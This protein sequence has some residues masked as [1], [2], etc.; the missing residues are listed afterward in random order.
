[1][2]LPAPRSLITSLISSLASIPVVDN[3]GVP[4]NNPA[5]SH[6]PSNQPS[7]PLRLIPPAY[8]SLLTTLHVL[9]PTTLL[10]A[11]DL[12]D[13]RLVTRIFL[14]DDLAR[15]QNDIRTDPNLTVPVNEDP[16]CINQEDYE[17][18]CDDLPRYHLVRS[19]QPQSHR[20]QHQH[21]QQ[22]QS[23]SSDQVYIV[24]LQSWNCT[25][26]AFAFSAFPPLS[27]PSF[28]AGSEQQ[29]QLAAGSAY[30]IFPA[31]SNAQEEEVGRS[32]DIDV[33]VNVDDK[34]DNND[35][36]DAVDEPW[37]FGGLST[38]G[39]DG[40][41]GVPCCKHLLACV[42]AERWHQVLGGYIEERV[43]SKEEGAGLVGDL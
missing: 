25:C 2:T 8:R 38:D 22:Q 32:G 41:G 42:L 18:R 34:D 15:H 29:Q 21:Q 31:S 3:A 9:Y 36:D 5:S 13:R 17:S 14:K 4:N 7:N 40:T 11:L 23:S 1:M 27:A 33:D 24:C 43:V 37:E 20:R 19:A 12:L 28:P 35:D 26:A 10:P 30:H 16:I 39:K 6:R